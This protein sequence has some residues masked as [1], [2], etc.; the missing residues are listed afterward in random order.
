MNPKSLAPV[1]PRGTVADMLAVKGSAVHAIGPTDTVY[2]AIRRMTELRVGA[3]LVMDGQ[4]LVGIVSERDYTRKV[5][6][7]GRASPD[8]RVE[9]IMSSPVLSVSTQA[10]LRECMV[11]TAEHQIRHLPVVDNDTV[12][13]V[14]SVNDLVRT[15]VAQQ[16][17]TIDSLNSYIAGDYPG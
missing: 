11:V 7:Q 5:M 6:L 15:I 3:L 17:E 1:I 12:V 4:R 13:G 8:T 16:A 14:L 10:T 9:E 2:E